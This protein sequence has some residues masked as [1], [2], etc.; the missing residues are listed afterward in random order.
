M[1]SPDPV[2][3]DALHDDQ[4]RSVREAFPSPHA[5]T[6]L[7]GSTAGPSPGLLH[8]A[9]TDG[10]D[11]GAGSAFAVV[12]SQY[13]PPSGAAIPTTGVLGFAG[14]APIEPWKTALPKLNTPPSAATSQ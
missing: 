8:S 4:A 1:Y 7:V 6:M 11:V 13:P 3:D 2:A 5:S 12:V 14:A 9:S 10:T